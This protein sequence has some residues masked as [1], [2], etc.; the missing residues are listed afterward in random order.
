MAAYGVIT[1]YAA[2][3]GTRRGLSVRCRDSDGVR[4]PSARGDAGAD[5]DRRDRAAARLVPSGRSPVLSCQVG[6][7]SS[8]SPSGIS[9]S[10]LSRSGG[11]KPSKL[12]AIQ[13]PAGGRS[14]SNR[15]VPW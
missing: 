8:H 15:Y 12:T 4:S 5:A 2:M 3:I 9:R 13:S 14:N 10:A 7:L 1:A 6:Q 11:Q